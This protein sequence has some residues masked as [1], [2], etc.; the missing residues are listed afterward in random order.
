MKAYLNKLQ[1]KRLGFTKI[2]KNNKIDNSLK[3]QKFKGKLGS[4]NRIDS[5][6]ILKGKVDFE[7][8]I[9]LARGC[10]LSG[11]KNGIYMSDFATLSNYV[12]VFSTSDDYKAATLSAGTLNQN[13]RKKYSKIYKGKVKIGKN[14]IIGSLS[15]ILPSTNI[16]DFV[17]I[18]P[19]SI[20]F[21]RLKKGLFYS[22][23]TS[24]KYKKNI[25]KIE[26]LYK[27]Y[28]LKRK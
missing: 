25:I 2:G 3:T 9:H 7:N 21:G 5:D 23:F 1:L 8:N 12:Q 15:I 6:V 22:S 14:C 27:K 24:K 16:E 26:K 18:S 10:T 11:S 19:L 28:L 4:N 13:E 17:T 20:I